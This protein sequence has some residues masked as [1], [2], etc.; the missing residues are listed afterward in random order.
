M[1]SDDIR[2][3]R[4]EYT[5]LMRHIGQ[6]SPGE[7]IPQ[8]AETQGRL[9]ALLRPV[10]EERAARAPAEGEWC[11]RELTLHA[12]FTERLVAKLVQCLSRGEMPAREDLEGA[13]IGM[14][15]AGDG[16]SFREAV[17]RLEEMNASLLEAVRGVPAEPDLELRLPHPFFGPLNSLEWAGFQCVHDLDHIQHAQRILAGMPA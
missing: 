10:G 15:P 16:A 7:I 3:R 4:E 8:V 2:G 1:V 12:A 5:Q 13:G 17:R 14:M 11:L 9:L 6:M